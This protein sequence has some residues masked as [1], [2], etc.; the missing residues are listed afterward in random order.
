ME[1]A[2]G[3]HFRRI[4]NPYFYTV[5]DI[6]DSRDILKLQYNNIASGDGGYSV[7][8]IDYFNTLRKCGYIK[9]ETDLETAKTNY[10]REI[11]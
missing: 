7:M 6:D 2:I 3:L 9:E 4:G 8:I 11:Q 10:E 1:L 5:V